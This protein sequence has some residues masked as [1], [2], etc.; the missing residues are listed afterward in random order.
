M[1]FNNLLSSVDIEITDINN[2][3]PS[4]IIDIIKEENEKYNSKLKDIIKIQND[5]KKELYEV[6]NKIN[7]GKNINEYFSSYEKS[8]T[9]Y[10]DLIKIKDSIDKIRL[11]VSKNKKIYEIIEPIKKEFLLSKKKL[12]EKKNKLKDEDKRLKKIN[13]AY[14]NMLEVYN[15]LDNLRENL[16]KLDKKREDLRG[17]LPIFNEINTLK[18]ELDFKQNI[19]KLFT[20][21]DNDKI[22]SDFDEYQKLVVKYKNNQN[23]LLDLKSEYDKKNNEYQKLF[24]K[25]INSQA[26]ILASYLKEG[27]PCPVCG[28][29]EHPKKFEYT[30]SD[31][32]KEIIDKY[33]DDLNKI[34]QSIIEVTDVVSEVKNK[35]D[36]IK[37]KIDAYDID[38]ILKENER[39]KLELND[40]EGDIDSYNKSDI[41]NDINCLNVTILEKSKSI[42]S[43]EDESSIVNKIDKLSKE[44]EK[45]DKEIKKIVEDYNKLT[46]EKVEIETSIKLLNDDIVLYE[47]DT[48]IKEKGYISAYLELGYKNEDDYLN[49]LIDKKELDIEERKIIN[50]DN[51]LLEIKSKIDTLKDVIKDKKKIDLSVLEDKKKELDDKFREYELS[52]RDYNNKIN[53]NK[54]IL[55]KLIS[56]SK[57][58][59]NIEEDLTILS[60]LSDTANGN[61]KGKNKLEFEQFVQA[62]Y[63]D[64][65]LESA[66]KRFSYMTDSRYLLLRKKSS[67]K[68]SDK[69]GLELEVMDYY[70]GKKRDITSLSGGESFKAS[71][72]LA[73]GMSDVIQS[74]SGGIVLDTM[75]IDE[76]FGSLDSDSLEQ[77]MN[78]IMMLN[79]NNKLIGIISH[80]NEL[81]DRIDKKIVVTKSNNGSMVNILV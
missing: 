42:T 41:E 36:E 54:I 14:D 75:F 3:M 43:G 46:Q 6:N 11:V 2:K 12:D 76:G 78:A 9:D 79:S 39:I 32:S 66:N 69:L 20:L 64:D 15:N 23:K 72:S 16:N 26:G 5:V 34:W 47:K 63:F 59:K 52:I 29:R 73:L 56:L 17:K 60:D 40:F 4:E 35:K 7:D 21:R 10:D 51:N 30:T 28:S 49:I 33:K 57:S 58:S 70:T 45:N 37:I 74:Y 77:A 24:D 25:F 13:K 55:E 31:V 19:L 18:K 50:Y 44:I 67:S 65:V 1:S 48:A 62:K 68:I 53:H 27:E 71:L 81:K 38:H 61:I 22:I 80:V 8:I